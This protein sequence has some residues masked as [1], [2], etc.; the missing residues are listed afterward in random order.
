MATQFLL[1]IHPEHYT[2]PPY[3]SE[4]IIEVIG[5]HRAR[6]RIEPTENVPAFVMEYGNA[7]FP[8]KKPTIAKLDDGTEA[9][10]MLHEF[11]DTVEGCLLQLRLIF[12][13]AAP[14]VFFDDHAEHLTIEF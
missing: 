11:R 12:P 7:A 3:D 8:M 10:Y 4:G 5:E 6:L 2:V 1:H 9:F 14:Q 13:A